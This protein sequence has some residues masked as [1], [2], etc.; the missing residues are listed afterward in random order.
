MPAEKRRPRAPTVTWIQKLNT[1]QAPDLHIL[2]APLP[3]P[4]PPLVACPP[5]FLCSQATP[6]YLVWAGAS[7]F[8]WAF[9]LAPQNR[10]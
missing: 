7:C 9:S 1:D 5:Q 3:H 8:L 2:P 4:F 10:C 6:M